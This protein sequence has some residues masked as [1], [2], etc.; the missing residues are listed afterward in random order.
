[1]TFDGCQNQ[2]ASILFACEAWSTLRK[3][4]FETFHRFQRRR[5]DP[6][7]ALQTCIHSDT[8]LVSFNVPTQ[9]MLSPEHRRNHF[10]AKPLF[11]SSTLKDFASNSTLTYTLCSS[12]SLTTCDCAPLPLFCMLCPVSSVSSTKSQITRFPAVVFGVLISSTGLPS[13]LT[14]RSSVVRLESSGCRF[15]FDEKGA[16]KRDGRP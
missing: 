9:D 5:S 4:K 15:E 13:S 7:Y 16:C 2:R 1:M 11:P 3:I 6:D 10:L 8:V 14:V 12:S